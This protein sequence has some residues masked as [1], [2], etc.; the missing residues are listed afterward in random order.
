MI[1]GDYQRRAEEVSCHQQIASAG[2]FS[3]AMLRRFG[4][5]SYRHLF[6]ETGLIGQDLYLEAEVANL[7]ATGVGCVFDDPVHETFG[8]TDMQF[9]SFY[10]FTVGARVEDPRLMTPPPYEAK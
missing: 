4:A 2:T 9:Q 6:W 3:V 8:L 7:G 10:H 5:P 1:E